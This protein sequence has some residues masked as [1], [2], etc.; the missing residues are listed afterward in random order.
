MNHT[1]PMKRTPHF[2]HAQSKAAHRLSRHAIALSIIA[3]LAGCAVT[4]VPIEPAER[5]T[6]LKLDRAVMY[7]NQEP[8]TADLTLDEA[9]ART[10][11]YNL[12]S[13]LKLMDQALSLGQIDVAQ[14][15]MLP[16]LV[17][18][19]GYNNRSNELVVDSMDV[20]TRQI[21]L[22]NTTSQERSHTT[23]DLN[24]TWNALDFGVS[25]F[26]A[27]QQADR[28]LIMKER[29]RKTIHQLMQQVRQTYWL[30]MG[31]QALEGRVGPLLNEVKGA[32]DN[33]TR[34]EQEKLRPP[35]ETLNY[36]KAMLDIVRQLEAMRDELGQA[37]PR[38]ATLMNLPPAA[39][40]SL[41]MPSELTLPSAPYT[42][43]AM[44][45]KALLQRPELYEA[46][47]QTRISV[48][49]TKK[50]MV[51]MLPGVEIYAGPHYDSNSFQHNQNWADAGLRVTWN[52]FNLLSGNKQQQLAELQVEITKSQR[53]ALNIAILTQVHVAWRDYSGRQR[54]YELSQ[55]LFEIDQKINSHTR[56]AAT[57]SAQSK[58]D[59]IRS[60][61]SELM[62]DYR[63]FQNYAAMQASYGQ[64]IA[65]MGQDPLP[66]GAI[67]DES[68][69]VLKVTEKIKEHLAKT[70]GQSQ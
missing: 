33:A 31:A 10:L 29:Q 65:S 66:V 24:F 47:L 16:R 52:L 25:Y 28:S 7:Q 59:A 64:L 63:R 18:A 62:A 35:L 54:Q 51:R 1:S 56:A 70:P 36:R 2:F 61:V 23:A 17:A 15:D 4:P 58:L 43:E 32:L 21:A 60:G 68:S 44:E 14:Y 22:G 34:V 39:P 12:E 30:A 42:I 9:M 26:Q 20:T 67:A 45:E 37:K 19:A 5:L 55:T 53:L 49:E 57:N 69:T 50:A 11:K 41:V 13:R 27:H 40:F 6:T 38:L 48:A 3:L 46:D 8:L